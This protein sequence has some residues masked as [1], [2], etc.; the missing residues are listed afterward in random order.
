MTDQVS[1]EEQEQA[2]LVSADRAED[3]AKLLLRKSRNGMLCTIS[4]K[5]AGWP[6]GSIAPYALDARGSPI[7]FIS[8]IAEHT[9]NLD[10]DD[11]V[12]ILVQEE[13]ADGDVQA[14]G[15]ITVLGRASRVGAEEVADVR[16]R[17]LERTPSAAGY[18]EAHDFHFYRIVPEHVRFIG[19][20]GKIFWL[21]PEKLRVDPAS[22]PLAGAASGVIEHMND[23]HAEAIQLYCRA[24][25]STTPA[26][27]KMV[28]VDQFGF[29]VEARG[30][31]ARFRFD[32]ERPATPD[33]IRAIVVEMVVRA[34]EKLGIP[35]R[36]ASK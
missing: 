10:A 36:G 7:L 5:I 29:D 6:F 4:K 17:Y 9:K 31:D 26:S 1:P 30:P 21:Q 8:T 11:R 14:H 24:F 34:R 2:Q 33:T 22:D 28:G 3:D 19:G 35:P 20:F 27:A 13:A 32:F 18:A 15:R 23:D 25:K 12:S 16:A